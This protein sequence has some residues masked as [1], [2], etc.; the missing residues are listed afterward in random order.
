[1]RWGEQITLIAQ[2]YDS[3]ESYNDIAEPKETQV[4]CNC[5]SASQSE[6]FRAA[7]SDITPEYQ[8]KM[9]AFDYSGEKLCRYNGEEFD[10]Y[11]TYKTGDTVELYL[12]RRSGT[13]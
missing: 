7:Q 5:L 2:K 10:I 9:W 13:Q 6:F 12:S 3:D 1:M 8:V 11:R 4:F